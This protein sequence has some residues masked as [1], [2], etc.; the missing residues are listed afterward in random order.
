MA[1]VVDCDVSWGSFET[2]DVDLLIDFCLK[3]RMISLAMSVT[4]AACLVSNA[5]E[6]HEN[7]NG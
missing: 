1:T 2:S 7:L 4:C 3:E 5:H 6:I